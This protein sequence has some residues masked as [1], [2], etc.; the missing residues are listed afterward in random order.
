MSYRDAAMK[1]HGVPR[2]AWPA[3]GTGLLALASSCGG[4]TLDGG[5]FG[6]DDA[7]AGS[8]MDAGRGD[9]AVAV[10]APA[11]RR[12]DATAGAADVRVEGAADASDGSI[13][14]A[15]SVC[16]HLPHVRP[17][18]PV[19][20][21]NG[22]CY[23]YPGGC[24]EGFAHCTSR[25]ED[26]CETDLSQPSHCG[27]CQ[28]T[29]SGQYS[30]CMRSNGTY[31]CIADCTPDRHDV[32]GRTCFDFQTDV[33]NCGRC[34]QACGEVPNTIAACEQGTCKVA[35]CQVGWGDCTADVGCETRL[36]QADHCGLCG[37][38]QCAV[39][40]A[41]PTCIS[42]GCG[43]PICQAGFAN[44][45]ATSPDCETPIGGA[46]PSC[47]P[48]YRGTAA[49]GGHPIFGASVAFAPDGSYVVGGDFGRSGDFDPTSGL[50]VRVPVPGSQDAFI[51]KLHADGS[52]AWTRTLGAEGEDLVLAV[53][54]APDG[55]IYATGHYEGAVDFDPGPGVDVHTSGAG[56]FEAFLLKLAADGSFVWA[57]TF[58]QG[59]GEG[60]QGMALGIAEDGS[61]YLGGG[62]S[63]T[64]DLDPGS[65][66]LSASAYG[67]GF[68]VKLTSGGELAWGRA[69]GGAKCQGEGVSGLALRSDG[70][71][72]VAAR[73]GS[74][75]SVDPMDTDGS[76]DLRLDIASFGP[77][78]D[79]RGAWRIHGTSE[80][81]SLAIGADNSVYVG[82]SFTDVVDFDPG[83]A[84]VE[85]VPGFSD[86]ETFIT[87]GF[88]LK[89]GL[90]GAF[91]WV[92]VFGDAP[93]AGVAASPTGVLGAGKNAQGLALF[94]LTAD[95]TSIFT[96]SAGNMDTTVRSL[97]V[98]D[99][100]FLIGG[101]TDGLG[102]FDPGPGTDVID[103]GAVHF[104]S[105][106]GF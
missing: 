102:D 12:A 44:C 55:S 13:D 52:Y 80:A 1:R 90:D 61:V 95:G 28:I 77:T 88:I 94:E 66:T 22:E 84:K 10:D 23:V 91:R 98:R 101:M 29:C 81:A 46:A 67:A 4:A 85:R 65:A 72:W 24:V 39:A 8:R 51:T 43:V 47:W 89:L 38:H 59:D 50:D 56:I 16:S 100:Q 32:C 103:R 26:G 64:I 37:N 75:C 83:P 36:D 20:C 82:G 87:S 40:N 19:P 17:D 27:G 3:W 11:D 6:G 97:V 71:V 60:A 58:A 14:P 7:G 68:L 34:N 48:K 93:I 31:M 15:C 5:V 9:R 62:F 33:H 45:D 41:T 96:L 99:G 35:R 57:K 73:E 69:L 2:R 18:V 21:R 79:Y 53:A 78:G 106:Y 76:T 74:A 104:A 49:L 25:P 105:R 54:V 30:S 63:G 70:A 86:D 42:T 92:Q